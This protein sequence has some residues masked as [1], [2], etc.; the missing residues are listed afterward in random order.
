MAVA[1]TYFSE[2]YCVFFTGTIKKETDIFF[3]SVKNTQTELWSVNIF[4]FCRHLRV[5]SVL[6]L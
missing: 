2:A 4:T 5:K 6:P 1:I 3:H